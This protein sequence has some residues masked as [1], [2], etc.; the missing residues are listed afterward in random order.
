MNEW[1]NER[2]RA[3]YDKITRYFN[4]L[5]KKHADEEELITIMYMIIHLIGLVFIFTAFI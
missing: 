3:T 2:S 5:E 4:V 1:R